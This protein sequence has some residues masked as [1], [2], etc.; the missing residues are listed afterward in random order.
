[1]ILLDGFLNFNIEKNEYGKKK[2]GIEIGIGWY[3]C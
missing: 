1:M 2:F 3:M